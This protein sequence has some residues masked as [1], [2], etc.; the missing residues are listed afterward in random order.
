MFFT[1]AVAGQEGAD[2][3]ALDREP[4]RPAAP[5]PALKASPR[6]ALLPTAG[7][8]LAHVA[9]GGPW[10][11]RIV[12]FNGDP[13][14]TAEGTLSFY[15]STGEP[16]RL[17]LFNGRKTVN[18]SNF[19]ISLPPRN[20]MFLETVDLTA[21]TEVGYAELQSKTGKLTGYG[22]FRAVL[23]GAPNLEAVVP[24]EWGVSDE[25]LLAYDNT[26]GF[27]TSVAIAN[28]WLFLP[29]EWRAEVYDEDGVFLASYHKMQPGGTH[30]AFETWREWPATAGRRGMVRL[31]R[32]GSSGAFAALALLFN[33][34]GS[35]TTAPVIDLP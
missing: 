22:I 9:A 34:T 4:P 12:L 35:L 8:V 13:G 15:R 27:V 7:G 16:L 28:R 6:G 29:C 10:R 30:T 2:F 32:V 3:Q 18:A 1:P 21:A 33:P 19:G 5:D 23:P 20:T 11:T 26:G 14:V 17:T 24:L 31:S 25:V